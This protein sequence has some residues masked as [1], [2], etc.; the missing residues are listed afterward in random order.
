MD[1]ELQR[2]GYQ[3]ADTMLRTL[4]TK[5]LWLVVVNLGLRP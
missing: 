4:A 3:E 5:F 2:N 1:G